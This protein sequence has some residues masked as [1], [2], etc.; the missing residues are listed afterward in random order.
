MVALVF[1]IHLSLVKVY[2]QILLYCLVCTMLKRSSLTV[3]AT[4]A[5]EVCVPKPWMSWEMPVGRKRVSMLLWL[6]VDSS[7]YAS[8]LLST[9][10]F[11]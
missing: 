8:I 1:N 3:Q 2:F 9:G 10:T 11:K 4:M 6:G 5:V 7:V